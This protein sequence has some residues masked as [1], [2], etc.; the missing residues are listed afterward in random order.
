LGCDVPAIPNHQKG[1]P[2]WFRKEKKLLPLLYK[3]MIRM[4]A[5]NASGTR[6]E[7]SS[8]EYAQYQY[9]YVLMMAA[10]TSLVDTPH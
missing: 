4:H 5:N 9:D 7:K 6:S 8:L 3:F 2:W 1:V 10:V